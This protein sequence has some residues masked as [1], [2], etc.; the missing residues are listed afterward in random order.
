[1]LDGRQAQEFAEEWYAAW[2][3][4]ELERILAHYAPDVVFSSPFVTALLGRE[5]GTVRGLAELRAYFGPALER[6]PDL[7]FEPLSLFVGVDSVVLHY[8]SVGGRIAAETMQLDE[9]GR[10]IRVLAH[11]AGGPG[12]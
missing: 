3:S 1:M 4:R 11:Y 7:H 10:V 9:Q 8:R 12:A 6:Y 5:D 2:N